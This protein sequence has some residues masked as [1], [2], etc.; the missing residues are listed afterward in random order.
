MGGHP[1]FAV[2]FLTYGFLISF[3]S[4]SEPSTAS[5]F[6]D[7]SILASGGE[8][9]T[10]TSLASLPLQQY[11]QDYRHE[12]AFYV[13]EAGAKRH[14]DLLS[15]LDSIMTQWEGNGLLQRQ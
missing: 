4:N 11:I 14:G 5:T 7:S 9:A 8:E 13:G 10:K 1:T 3:E 12:E 6:S 15:L 2:S